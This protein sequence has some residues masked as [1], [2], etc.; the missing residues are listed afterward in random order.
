MRACVPTPVAGALPLPAGLA[1]EQLGWAPQAVEELNA[2]LPAGCPPL[3]TPQ[4]DARVR[5][6]GGGVG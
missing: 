6:R 2:A 4:P 3:A 5:A 1:P